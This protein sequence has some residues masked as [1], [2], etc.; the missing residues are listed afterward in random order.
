VRSTDYWR[1]PTEIR[2][3]PI[4][5]RPDL[6]AAAMPK[7]SR[8]ERRHNSEHQHQKNRLQRDPWTVQ[9]SLVLLNSWCRKCK[10]PDRLS[11]G[12]N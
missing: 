4:G 5:G 9:Q 12:V 7:R 3:L 6:M 10:V 11:I 8:T 1:S 2:S